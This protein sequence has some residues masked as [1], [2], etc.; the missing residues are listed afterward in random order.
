MNNDCISH[1]I[2]D[3]EQFENFEDIFEELSYKEADNEKNS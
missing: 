1:E 2:D 3:Y